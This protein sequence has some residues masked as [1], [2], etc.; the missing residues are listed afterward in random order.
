MNGYLHSTNAS[1]KRN[2]YF[3]MRKTELLELQNPLW[4]RAGSDELGVARRDAHI[5]F[6]SP[7]KNIRCYCSVK[8]SVVVSPVL[9]VAVALLP[10][11]PVAETVTL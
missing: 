3:V 5:V 6:P 7:E 1:H 4:A 9:T 8:F 2:L 11:K 10:V